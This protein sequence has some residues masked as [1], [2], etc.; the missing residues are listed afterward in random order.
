[1]EFQNASTVWPVTPRLLPA[2]MNVTE[3]RI[4]TIFFPASDFRAE[5]QGTDT[6]F[7]ENILNR[8]KRGLGVQRV[9][10]GFDEQQIRA[11]IEQAADL[12]TDKP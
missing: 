1:M 11:A 5:G 4:G 9:K 12:F 2:W 10:N 3:A 7:I 6:A 8:E